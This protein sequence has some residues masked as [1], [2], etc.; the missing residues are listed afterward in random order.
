VN[1]RP[2]DFGFS[3]SPGNFVSEAIARKSHG[4]VSHVECIVDVGAGGTLQVVSAEAS[5]M[6]VIWRIPENQPWYCILTMNTLTLRQRDDLCKWM[7]DHKDFPYDYW[8]LASFLFDVDMSNDRRL[9]CSEAAILG[10]EEGC[11]IFPFDGMDHNFISP[12]MF[13]ANPLLST[14]DGQRK[15]LR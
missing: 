9:F 10:L 6:N 12:I 4:R 2:G 3:F 11:G 13:Y 5:G 8:G 14:L 7:W 15:E 1:I